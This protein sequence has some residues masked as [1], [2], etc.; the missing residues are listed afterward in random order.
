MNL[1]LPFCGKHCFSIWTSSL[2]RGACGPSCPG[3]WSSGSAGTDSCSERI[4]E[5][6]FSLNNSWASI[7]LK[8]PTGCEHLLVSWLWEE[9]LQLPLL[10]VSIRDSFCT[11]RTCFM[12]RRPNTRSECCQV[13]MEPV[14]EGRDMKASGQC[15]CQVLVP[16]LRDIHGPADWESTHLRRVPF[17]VEMSLR[18]EI[19]ICTHKPA[20]LQKSPNCLLVKHNVKQQAAGRPSSPLWLLDFTANT[21]LYMTLNTVKYLICRFN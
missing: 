5:Q 12:S 3:T 6:N 11:Y 1:F 13:T 21:Q 10:F 20:A 14:T 18:N 17:E 16:V 15:W 7:S 4:D 8:S 9:K 19:Y 2:R